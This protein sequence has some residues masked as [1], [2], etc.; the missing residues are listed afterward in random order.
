MFNL[1]LC[2]RNNEQLNFTVE[3]DSIYGDGVDLT[4]YT[5]PP[6]TNDFTIEEAT[7]RDNNYSYYNV[8]VKAGVVEEIDKQVNLSIKTI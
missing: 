6:V 5:L 3:K 8:T 2:K 4:I 7:Q 1:L